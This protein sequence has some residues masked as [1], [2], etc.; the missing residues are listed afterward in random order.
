TFVP[1]LIA[2]QSA[3]PRA[4]LG[5]A[6]SVT[7]FLRTLGGAVG[8]SVMG[9]VMTQ[10]LQSGLPMA[11]ALHGVFVVGLVVGVLALASAFLVPAGRAQDLARADM[12]G[13]PTRAGG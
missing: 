12:R 1:M 8:L 5:A 9:A 2:V 11:E 10:R 7:Q 13:E 3:V 6:T 4:D